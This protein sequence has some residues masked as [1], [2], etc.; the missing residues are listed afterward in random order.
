MA[1]T[2]KTTPEEVVPA[3]EV[4]PVEEVTTVVLNQPAPERVDT[5]YSSRDFKTPLN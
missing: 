2:N 1:K 5:G 4:T 3:E